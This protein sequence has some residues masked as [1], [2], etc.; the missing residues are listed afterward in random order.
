MSEHISV[1]TSIILAKSKDNIL[2]I[3]IINYA[4]LL[5]VMSISIPT[6]AA[7]VGSIHLRDGRV[8]EAL[9]IDLHGISNYK[10]V[11][12]T[13]NSQEYQIEPDKISSLDFLKIHTD[14]RMISAGSVIMVNL[15][16]GKS[17][18][19]TNAFISSDTKISFL[20]DFTGKRVTQRFYIDGSNDDNDPAD[21]IRI[22]F[23]S[24][25]SMKYSKSS[26]VYFPPGFSFDP[27]T[28]EKLEA[29]IITNNK[30]NNDLDKKVFVKTSSEDN[31]KVQ[32]VELDMLTKKALKYA[33]LIANPTATKEQLDS[34][35]SAFAAEA[36]KSL[37]KK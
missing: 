36:K 25:G 20:D 26:N 23:S 33:E 16:N 32:H 24:T 11:S 19:A 5:L 4:I 2:N 12:L 14:K 6:S 28:G 22:S 30:N 1:Y 18:T 35:L 3:R 29:S 34:G 7:I 21:I 31:R 27:Y 10:K 17:A 8:I 9:N 37:S 13:I 15:R